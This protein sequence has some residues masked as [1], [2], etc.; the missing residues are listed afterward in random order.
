MKKPNLEYFATLEEIGAAIGVMISV[1]YLGIQIQGSN[2]QLRAQ[3]YSDTLDMLHKPVELLVQDQRLSDIARQAKLD[4]AQLTESEWYRYSNLELLRFD[5]YEHAYYANR[6]GEI[7]P[8]LWRGIDSSFTKDIKSDPGFRRY[9]AQD[10]DA[11]AEPFH[12]F[13]E[14]K[15][16]KSEP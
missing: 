3:S 4:P 15:L 13:I 10:G 14:M 5:A 7:Q 9:W 16:Q 6:K 11:F 2:E 12:S 1:I 8:E